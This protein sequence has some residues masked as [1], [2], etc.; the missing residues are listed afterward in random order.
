MSVVLL[1]E[2]DFYIKYF[3]V[4]KSC[5][6]RLLVLPFVFACSNSCAVFN[7]I[8]EVK[9]I[10]EP[11]QYQVKFV[12]IATEIVRAKCMTEGQLDVLKQDSTIR[13]I[14]VG[15]VVGNRDRLR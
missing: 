10:C 6:L 4:S 15:Y 5:V 9:E 14:S 11:G 12:E 3:D 1:T 13:I 7:Y 2:L 8:F